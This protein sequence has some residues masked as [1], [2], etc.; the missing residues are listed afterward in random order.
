MVE[1]PGTA[2]GSS[3]ALNLL[4]HCILFILPFNLE[5]NLYSINHISF[6]IETFVHL[7]AV[8]HTFTVYTLVWILFH[9]FHTAFVCSWFLLLYLGLFKPPKH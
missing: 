7:F 4:Q 1:P 2:P 8:S 9:L 5:V 3:L 6:S